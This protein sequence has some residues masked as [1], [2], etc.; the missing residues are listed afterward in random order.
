MS[1]DLNVFSVFSVA[2]VILVGLASIYG[3]KIVKRLYNDEFSAAMRWM[4]I[5]VEALFIVQLITFL[6]IYFSVNEK[7]ISLLS[8]LLLIF[9]SLLFFFATYKIVHFVELYVFH[10]KKLPEKKI[11][12][13]SKKRLK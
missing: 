4:L 1:L 13:L 2:S 11:I 8:M 7:V 6:S 9:I 12:L 10:G 5:I 3:A